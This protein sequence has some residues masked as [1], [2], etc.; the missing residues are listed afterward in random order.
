VTGVPV[1]TTAADG[2]YTLNLG[3]GTFTIVATAPNYASNSIDVTVGTAD[4]TGQDIGL[5]PAVG[6]TVGGIVKT[7]TG[8]PLGG[9]IVTATGGASATSTYTTSSPAAPKGDGKPLNWTLS[10]QPGTYTITFSGG[11]GAIAPKTNIVVKASAFTRVPDAQ[12]SSA[13]LIGL[14]KSSPNGKPLQGGKVT[15][16]DKNGVQIWTIQNGV[17]VPSITTTLGTSTPASPSGDGDPINYSATLFPDTYTIVFSKPGAADKTQTV[18]LVAD[19]VTRVNKD[20]DA[21]HTY[22]VGLHFLSLPYD[23]SA[24][25]WDGLFGNYDANKTNRSR[26][27]IWQQAV[28][29][30]V[31][32][33]SAPADSPRLG[34]GYWIRLYKPVD[35]N[36]LGTVPAASQVSVPLTKGWNM[37]GVPSTTGVSVTSLQFVN[38][39]SQTPLSWSDATGIRYNLVSPT[40]YS[41]NEGTGAYDP[42]TTGGTLEPWKGYWIRA[43]DNATLK[44]PTSG[45]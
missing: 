27:A 5:T 9:I 7:S 40:L 44:I 35:I 2:T 11:W 8:G 45:S 14:V 16:Y 29:Q 22:T 18:T 3:T 4:V 23:Y 6:G 37:I 26:A 41:Y 25:G 34:Y 1:A 33:P 42:V 28:G 39:T 30:Y 10:L 17:S 20:F 24:L 13:Q 31:F 36:V 15:I 38:P 32:D 21:L 19:K 43:N 12:L